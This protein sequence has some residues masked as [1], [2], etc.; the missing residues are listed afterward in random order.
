[1]KALEGSREGKGEAAFAVLYSCIAYVT[2]RQERTTTFLSNTSNYMVRLTG[3]INYIYS[4]V[5][6]LLI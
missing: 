6:H 4:L 3:I 1:M 2:S 5:I